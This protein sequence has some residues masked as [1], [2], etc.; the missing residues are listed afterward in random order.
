[1]A[2]RHEAARIATERSLLHAVGA[3]ARPAH[4]SGGKRRSETFFSGVFVAGKIKSSLP[5]VPDREGRNALV[6]DGI[7]HEVIAHDVLA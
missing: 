7:E 3:I 6:V 5:V 4:E 1:M 2:T